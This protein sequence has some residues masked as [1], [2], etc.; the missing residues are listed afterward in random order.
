MS[1]G[2]A[3]FARHGVA[4]DLSKVWR[5]VTV[6]RD[7]ALRG[8]AWPWHPH[9]IL[10]HSTA[11]DEAEGMLKGGEVTRED[12]E[13]SSRI[14]PFRGYVF[15]GFE[16][17]AVPASLLTDLPMLDNLDGEGFW[18]AQAGLE[19]RDMADLV[20][21]A[22]DRDVACEVRTGCGNPARP[23]PCGG[24][25]AMAVPPAIPQSSTDK[26]SPETLHS[27]LFCITYE[28]Q[29]SIL[30]WSTQKDRVIFTDQVVMRNIRPRCP[31]HSNCGSWNEELI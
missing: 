29:H 14:V 13:D 30:T 19:T 1:C 24:R 23:D 10:A 4:C 27:V 9:D 22:A 26:R 7:L 3:A 20:E 21:L 16:E 12:A 11:S 6:R 2:G 5:S 18:A 28:A 31:G 17:N 25:P 15:K 8:D